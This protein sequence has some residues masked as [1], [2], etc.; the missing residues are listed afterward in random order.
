MPSLLKSSFLSALIVRATHARREHDEIHHLGC[1]PIDASLH[2]TY[3]EEANGLQRGGLWGGGEVAM[4]G[5]VAVGGEVVGLN[6]YRNTN[7]YLSSIPGWCLLGS[8]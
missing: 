5:E 6:T 1:L 2:E 8:Y 3:G 7:W 4:V